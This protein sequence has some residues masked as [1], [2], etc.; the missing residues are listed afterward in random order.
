MPS[1][2]SS[3]LNTLER[4]CEALEAKILQP[5]PYHPQMY[6]SSS[7][8]MTLA[9]H[10]MRT[11]PASGTASKPS[12]MRSVYVP[13]DHSISKL[14]QLKDLLHEVRSI[15]KVPKSGAGVGGDM[16]SSSATTV[17]A[18]PPSTSVA[19]ASDAMTA[20]VPRA[21]LKER[22]LGSDVESL[23]QRDRLVDKLESI[24]IE[25]LNVLL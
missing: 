15:S 20:S 8:T 12:A 10:S 13:G 16:M 24:K 5:A 19:A 2:I 9:P 23:V 1:T 25:M 4:R 7:G 14:L 11:T 17:A 3:Q 21:A 18:L 6:Q 22:A